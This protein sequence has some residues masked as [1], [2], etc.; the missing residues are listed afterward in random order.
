MNFFRSQKEKMDAWLSGVT[1]GERRS[2]FPV[3]GQRII[4]TAL[5]VFLCMLIYVARGYQGMVIQSTIAAIICM[6]PYSS[7]SRSF[8][9]SRVIGTVMGGFWGLAFLWLLAAF[10]ILS[11][12]MEVVYLLMSIG[13]ALALYSCVLTK[14]SG[15]AALTAIVFLC[16]IITYPEIEEPFYQTIARITDTILGVCVAVF[17]NNVHLPMERHPEKLFFVRLQDLVEDRYSQVSSKVLIE[18]NR[19]YDD[20]ARICLISNWAPAFLISQM[21]LLKINLPVIVMDGAALYDI[22]ENTYYEV[23]SIPYEDVSALLELLEGM[24]LCVQITSV[25]DNT[26][27]FYHRGAL[28]PS[29]NEDYQ[30]MRRSPYRNYVEGNFHKEDR[31]AR[32]RFLVKDEEAEDYERRLRANTELMQRFRLIR[33]A[34]PRMDGIT[35]FY[36]YRQDVSVADME[37][38]LLSHLQDEG[39]RECVYVLPRSLSYH[40]DRDAPILLHRLKRMYAKPSL[41]ALFRRRH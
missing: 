30:I 23:R 31:I 18:L 37:A 41:R 21:G 39:L 40:P 7:D 8:A 36:F 26:M 10:P 15:S 3:I 25:R 17:V 5:A 2:R 35:G 27:F 4:K 14:L 28:S 9:I 11:V 32:I 29:E 1:D 13:V 38:Q 34:Q 16:V 19:L 22:R 12:R 24:G 20:G 33:H 6:Q